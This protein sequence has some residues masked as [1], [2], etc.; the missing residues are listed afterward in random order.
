MAE[1][2]NGVAFTHTSKN[3]IT[4]V[5]SNGEMPKQKKPSKKPTTMKNIVAGKK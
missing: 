5:E 2:S 1:N 3:T 4:Y